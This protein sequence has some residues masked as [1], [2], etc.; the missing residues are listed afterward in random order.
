MQQT[1]RSSIESPPELERVKWHAPLL[2][3]WQRCSETA[4]AMPVLGR[5]GPPTPPSGNRVARG[6]TS[7]LRSPGR[8]LTKSSYRDWTL[9]QTR[10]CG[11]SELALR[12]KRYALYHV[13]RRERPSSADPPASRVAS[14]QS[15]LPR[16]SARVDQG[17]GPHDRSSR[18]VRRRGGRR[19]P[20]DAQGSRASSA[21]SATSTPYVDALRETG[22]VRRQSAPAFWASSIISK[23]LGSEVDLEFLADIACIRRWA[24]R[25]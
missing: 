1:R 8:P 15:G 12:S 11:W 23:R 7:V 22:F 6:R 18:A 19:V 5:R 14:A 21:P 24:T 3:L 17:G 9:D 4:V 10:I 20:V 2:R 16:A 25:T 13:G